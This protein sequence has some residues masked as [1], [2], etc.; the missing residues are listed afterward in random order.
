MKNTQKTKI[1]LSPLFIFCLADTLNAQNQSDKF[2]I[3]KI[4]SIRTAR[5]QISDDS[6]QYK[7]FDD[8]IN[9]VS[10][11]KTFRQGVLISIHVAD[12]GIVGYEGVTFHIQND[13]L[14]YVEHQLSAPDMYSSPPE[15]MTKIVYFRNDKP[16]HQ[17]TTHRP[18]ISQL[19]KNVTF[20]NKDFVK[21]FYLYKNMNTEKLKYIG[22][23]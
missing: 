3:K 16:I 17:F 23:D 11:V 2:Y 1:I 5:E 4:D 21:G 18:G 7:Q 22:D 8:T 15:S 13:S 12:G 6:L 20:P 14:L 9:D 10:L 19:P